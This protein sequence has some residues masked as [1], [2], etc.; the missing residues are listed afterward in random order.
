MLALPRSL[1]HGSATLDIAIKIAAAELEPTASSESESETQEPAAFTTASV[2]D[3]LPWMWDPP[4]VLG[5]ILEAVLGAIFVD[6]GL[7]LDEVFR[8]LDSVFKD[9]TPHLRNIEKRDPYSKIIMDVQS[10]H[11]KEV[12]IKCVRFQLREAL[13]SDGTASLR[14]IP[15]AHPK[16]QN[17]AYEATATFHGDR[18][19]ATRTS[20]SKAVARQLAAR[21]TLEFL[22]SPAGDAL[23]AECTCAADEARAKAARAAAADPDF[24]SDVEDALGAGA[25][26][27]VD[28]EGCGAGDEAEGESFAFTYYDAGTLADSDSLRV[29]MSPL[30]RRVA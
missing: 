19:L 23:F 4:K 29:Q 24:A 27:L 9:V 11:C 6:D 3:D 21:D 7:R 8:V 17:P 12:K 20:S 22:Q 18:Q 1:L 2:L 28:L 5:D 15:T 13:L 26:A 25:D 30:T 14:V 16:S 10:R